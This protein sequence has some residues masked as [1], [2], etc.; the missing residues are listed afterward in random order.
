MKNREL[1]LIFEKIGNALEFKGEIPFKVS[2]YRRVAK[3]L[4]ELPQDVEEIWKKGE[5]RKIPGVGE[6]IA[7]KIDEYL[8]T[9]RMKKFEEA[10]KGISEDLL[11]LLE[12]QSLGP[13][14][15]RLAYEKLGVDCEE[16]LEKVINDG[17]LASL[18][19]MGEKKVENIKK[20]LQLFKKEKG[21]ISIGV[22][23]PLAEE[24]INWMKKMEVEKIAP[25]GSLRRMKETIGDIDILVAHN[26]GEEVVKHFTN[27]PKAERV[28]L[29]G[30]T[31]GS[32]LV[33]GGYQVDIRVVPPNCYGAALQ[34]FTGSKAHNIKLRSIAK[35]KGLKI[36][37]Y[38]V[39]KGEK[40]VA[41]ETEESV[42]NALGLKWIPPEL[43]EDRG[44]VEK[45][46]VEGLIEYGDI[47]GDLHI[48]SNYS[49][50]VNSIEE[51]AEY[52][53]KLGYRYIAITDHSKS[54][55][56]ARGIDEETLKLQIKEIEKVE[57]RIGIRILKGIEVE[58]KKDGTP[59][60]DDE[61]LKKLDVVIGA[62]HIFP[63]DVDMTPTLL[64]ACRNPHIHIIAH[65][66]GRLISKRE[67]YK[68]NIERVI[69][70]AKN[71]NTY[72]E[73][74]SYPERLDLNDVWARMAK[75]YGV[76]IVIGSDAH[77]VGMLRIIRFGVGVARRGWLTK[78]E[79][80]NT[81]NAF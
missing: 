64:H 80:V 30:K 48:H 51:I 56:Y 61:V 54:A 26:R 27:F 5:L 8:R 57:K 24:V 32:I 20:G 9:G 62:I 13:K 65:P 50:G 81:Q 7:K 28:L 21:R 37:E 10:T 14:T 47:L 69:K 66:T 78:W 15:L 22:A 59:D 42:Y 76:K 68:V 73:I 75:E 19:G 16:K 49:D 3:I 52:A 34:Y 2:A 6:G 67:G 79:V 60:F 31:K 36:S 71:T 12:I 63:K 17:S 38:G 18:P 45:N 41:G 4:E 53:K 33:Y 43:R 77:N 29:Q 70:E 40:I 11:K 44:E 72:L 39:F 1:A 74:N 58:L 23:L 25:A 55:K 46:G 35:E